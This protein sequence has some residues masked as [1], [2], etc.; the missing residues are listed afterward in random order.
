M[1]QLSKMRFVT[2]SEFRGKVM[3]SIREHYEAD[4]ELRPGKKGISLNL[5]QWNQLKD[6]MDEIDAVVKDLK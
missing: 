2:V 1:F 5:E 6:Q 3:V 4:G